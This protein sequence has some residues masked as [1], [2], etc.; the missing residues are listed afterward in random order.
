MTDP[1]ETSPETP[2]AMPADESP[3]SALPD[4][5]DSEEEEDLDDDEEDEEEEEDEE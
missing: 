4:D 2:N 3:E 5:E 1:D